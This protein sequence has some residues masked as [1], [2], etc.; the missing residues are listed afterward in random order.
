MS[1][2][3]IGSIIMTSKAL[4]DVKSSFEH[5]VNSLKDERSG[6]ERNQ[7]TKT[8]IWMKK[9]VSCSLEGVPDRPLLVVIRLLMR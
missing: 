2:T 1:T 8:E 6:G 5:E 4:N 3:V 9:T 7:R